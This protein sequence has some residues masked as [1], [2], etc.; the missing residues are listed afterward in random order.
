MHDWGY[1]PH[2]LISLLL[3]LVPTWMIMKKAGF[4]PALSLFLILPGLGAIIVVAILAF[5]RWPA[6]DGGRA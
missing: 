5:A 3:L 4:N 2:Y 6:V 1:G